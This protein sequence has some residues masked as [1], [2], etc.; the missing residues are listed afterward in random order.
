LIPLP[1]SLASFFHHGGTAGGGG[2]AALGGGMAMKAAAVG[3][4]ALLVTGAGIEGAKHTVF[5]PN[6]PHASAS[7]HQHAAAVSA[8][9]T[10]LKPAAK[11]TDQKPF[12]RA[13]IKVRRSHHGRPDVRKAHPSNPGHAGEVSKLPPSRAHT[14]HVKKAN[15]GHHAGQVRHQTRTPKPHK[16]QKPK[17]PKHNPPPSHSKGNGKGPSG[18]T[19]A[20]G[21]GHANGK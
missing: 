19:G 14:T 20:Q 4:G 3:A 11:T 18:D 17:K 8:V 15:S 2:A 5:R 16:P 1:T 13:S 12:R 21:N 9:Q 6:R 7:A 10:A